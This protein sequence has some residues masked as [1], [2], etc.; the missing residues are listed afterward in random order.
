[1]PGGADQKK[2]NCSCCCTFSV[3][4]PE[5]E[6]RVACAP[7]W[8]RKS[9]FPVASNH[10]VLIS[11]TL[12]KNCS[13]RLTGWKMTVR[14]SADI[15]LAGLICLVFLGVFSHAPPVPFKLPNESNWHNS[16]ANVKKGIFW[17]SLLWHYRKICNTNYWFNYLHFGFLKTTEWAH[18]MHRY[19]ILK[20]HNIWLSNYFTHIFFNQYETHTNVSNIQVYTSI[21]NVKQTTKN[22]TF[23]SRFR[24]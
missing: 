6:M 13:A 23:V 22:K 19:F 16:W 8:G 9:I 14:L 4:P 12:H 20:L 21:F 11:C 18:N 2:T 3:P 7:C 15:K 24:I 1:M 5:S 10:P 17:R